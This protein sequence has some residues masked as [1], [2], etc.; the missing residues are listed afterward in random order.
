MANAAHRAACNED[1]GSH[2]RNKPNANDPINSDDSG[3][4]SVRRLLRPS[5]VLLTI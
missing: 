5:P 1:N 3:D 2:G 4:R